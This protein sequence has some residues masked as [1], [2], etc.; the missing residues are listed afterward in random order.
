MFSRS[1]SVPSMLI[2][3]AAFL[4]CSEQTAPT[5]A[6][7]ATP[8]AAFDF[9]KGP[10]SPGKS[11]IL[12]FQ[13]LYFELAVDDGLISIHGLRNTIADLCADEGDIALGDFQVKPHKGG[14]RNSL[15]V[16]RNSPVQILA[17]P[18]DATD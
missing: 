1:R 16:D 15:I 4:S 10:A 2:I 12:R 9:A 17:L 3:S 7:P 13:D 8:R 11:G 5:D 18:P 6:V 14:E